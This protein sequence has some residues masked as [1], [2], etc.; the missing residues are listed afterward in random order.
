VFP[1]QYGAPMSSAD[2]VRMAWQRRHETD[3]VFD[4]WTAFG[5]TILTC[6]I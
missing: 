6:G 4:F 2:R 5:W 1:A 3:Y